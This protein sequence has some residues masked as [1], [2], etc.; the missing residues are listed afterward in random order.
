MCT[1]GHRHSGCCVSRD[2]S[3]TLLRRVSIHHELRVHA[4][5]G[6]TGSLVLQIDA[7]TT[8]RHRQVI[9]NVGSRTLYNLH[10][11]STARSHGT[12]IRFCFVRLQ[13]A[14]FQHQRRAATTAFQGE[15]TTSN[16]RLAQAYN[17]TNETNES[18]RSGA[19]LN[20]ESSPIVLFPLLQY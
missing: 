6:E 12:S 10:L 13:R 5:D 1:R 16:R 17:R 9:L 2:T 11:S 18:V 7:T 14:V 15:S 19:S 4:R 20:V 8:L 3:A